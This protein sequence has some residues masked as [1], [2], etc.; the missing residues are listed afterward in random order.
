MAMRTFIIIFSSIILVSCNQSTE[1]ITLLQ[2]QVDSLNKVLSNSYK[3][4]FGEFMSSI[5][6]HHAKL[7][8]A[9]QNENWKLADF[10]IHE[11]MEAVENI[12]KYET[13]RKESTQVGMINASLDSVNSAI[14]S[15]NILSFRKAYTGM[16][17]TCNLCH[18]VVNFEFNVVKIPESQNFSNQDFRLPK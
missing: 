11:M 17:N 7:W 2:N 1:K 8:F 3:P 16:T 6:A 5:Q 14:Q 13:D 15:K 9:G 12:K 18:K 4:G 10:E